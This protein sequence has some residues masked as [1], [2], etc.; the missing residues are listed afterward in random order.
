MYDDLN[1]PEALAVMWELLRDET[2]VPFDKRETL[3]EFDRVL[4][5][6]FGMYSHST[7]SEK[8][9]VVSVSD[10]PQEVS[11]LVLK[12]EEARKNGDWGLADVLRNTLLEKGFSVEDTKDGP[13]VRKEGSF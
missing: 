12:R 5:I 2:V 1:T 3:L 7:E 11:D 6:G 9:A 8:L 4:G 10:L 13:H